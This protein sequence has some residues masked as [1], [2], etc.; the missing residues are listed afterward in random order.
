MSAR[1]NG[2]APDDATPLFESVMKEIERCFRT[3]RLRPGSKLPPERE[4]AA[5]FGVSRHT[6]REV[7]KALNL[8]GIIRSRAGDGTYV[9][10]SLSGLVAKAIGLSALLEDVNYMD[11]FNTRLAIEP[12]LARIAAGKARREHL[13]MMRREIHE[14]ELS[15][16][17]VQEYTRHEVAFHELIVTA[18]D[19]PILKSVM[20][21]VAGLLLEARLTIT[22]ER[23]DRDDLALHAR[24][25]DAIEAR[26]P[27]GAFAAMAHH[28]NVNRKYYEAYF[29]KKTRE[30]ES[31]EESAAVVA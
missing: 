11:A 6:L 23:V 26:D 25:L 17:K 18:A 12:T 22:Y 19:N 14:M 5:E 15:L 20:T 31:Q 1:K 7:L 24:I 13:E 27:D 4:L 10:R 29:R 2:P 21:A 30:T 9:Q 3:K 8:F 16:G 28:L